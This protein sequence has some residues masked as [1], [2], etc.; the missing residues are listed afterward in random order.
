MENDDPRHQGM[1]KKLVEG[2]RIK[3]IRDENVLSAIEKVP[4]HLFMESSFLNFAYKD[5]AF[6]IGSG[7]TISQ[8]YTVAFQTQLLEVKKN[9]KILEVGTGSGY[10]AAVLLE[11]GAR[12]YTIER[13]KDLFLKAQSFLPEIGYHPAC[14][15]GDGWLGLPGFAPF[16]KILVTAGAPSVPAAL[17][18]QLKTGG[19][20]VIPVGNENRQE[21]IVIIR[22]S[23]NEFK[24]EK[25]GGFIF[26]PL[27][28]GTVN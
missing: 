22:I 5:Q 18:E 4:R 7:Q 14:F 11:M 13:Q 8:P 25:H 10:Q 20:L 24:S 23:E 1:R 26:V 19:R 17:K 9:D 21:M 27:L 12:L 3:G 2:L 16:D 28:K 15:F 6:P